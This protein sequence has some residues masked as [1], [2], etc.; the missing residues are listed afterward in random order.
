MRFSLLAAATPSMETPPLVWMQ[1]RTRSA[2]SKDELNDMSSPDPHHENFVL[3]GLGCSRGP[4]IL[5]QRVSIPA[6]IRSKHFA[7]AGG[8]A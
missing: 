3:V 8:R 4:S 2:I 7:T 5:C 1:A 6:M